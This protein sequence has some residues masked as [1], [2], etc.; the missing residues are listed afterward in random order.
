MKRRRVRAEDGTIITILTP[1]TVQEARALQA[2]QAA[3]DAEGRKTV[4]DRHSFGDDPQRWTET[5]A[6]KK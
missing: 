4:D 6:K 5:D 1:E 2:A 3:G